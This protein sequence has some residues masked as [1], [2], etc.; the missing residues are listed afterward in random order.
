MIIELEFGQSAAS[1]RWILGI[2]VLDFR[3]ATTFDFR[4]V[5]VAVSVLG[6]IVFCFFG[7]NSRAMLPATSPSDSDAF[8][9]NVRLKL[10]SPFPACLLLI[11]K[12][13]Q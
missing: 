7:G 11:P 8:C 6:D 9:F 4:T 13:L 5:T 12:L 2:S 1:F 10:E 3:T